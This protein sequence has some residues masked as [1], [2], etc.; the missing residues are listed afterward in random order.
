MLYISDMRQAQRPVLKHFMALRNE[1]VGNA[2]SQ[3]RRFIASDGPDEAAR[4]LCCA[5]LR[6]FGIDHPAGCVDITAELALQQRICQR[7]TMQRFHMNADYFAIPLTKCIFCGACEFLERLSPHRASSILK[8][9]D[10]I[11]P[12]F[13]SSSLV[14]GSERAAFALSLHPDRGLVFWACRRH[15]S[16]AHIRPHLVPPPRP[17]TIDQAENRVRVKLARS[18]FVGVELKQSSFRN[19]NWKMVRQEGAFT[20]FSTTNVTADVDVAHSFGADTLETVAELE[21][22]VVAT[23]S[24]VRRFAMN[25]SSVWKFWIEAK[26]NDFLKDHPIPDCCGFRAVPMESAFT[27]TEDTNFGE[28]LPDA[29]LV[30]YFRLNNGFGSPPPSA[31]FVFNEASG[32]ALH[33]FT[34]PLV[35]FPAELRKLYSANCGPDAGHERPVIFFHLAALMNNVKRRFAPQKAK[36]KDH[37][38]KQLLLRKLLTRDIRGPHEAD[39]H[40]L[41][42]PVPANDQERTRLILDTWKWLSRDVLHSRHISIRSTE[43]WKSV[44]SRSQKPAICLVRRPLSLADLLAAHNDVES[45]IFL[46]CVI[47]FDTS[48]QTRDLK[49]IREAFFMTQIWFRW[50]AVDY[51]WTYS[52]LNRKPRNNRGHP[53]IHPLPFKGNLG[54]VHVIVAF[55]ALNNARFRSRQNLALLRNVGGIFTNCP[56]HSGYRMIR[57]RSR[58]AKCDADGCDN[59]AT[60]KCSAPRD[61]NESFCNFKVCETCHL[62]LASEQANDEQEASTIAESN[63]VNS[64]SVVHQGHHVRGAI[65][66]NAFGKVLA[67]N[68]SLHSKAMDVVSSIF[69][70]ASGLSSTVYLEPLFFPQIFW[71]SDDSGAFTGISEYSNFLLIAAGALPLDLLADTSGTKIGVDSL[72]NH[73]WSRL[74][75]NYSVTATDEAYRGVCFDWIFN[76]HFKNRDSRFIFSRGAESIIDPLGDGL[77]DDFLKTS[78]FASAQ[79]RELPF[80][81]Y[82]SKRTVAELCA[83]ARQQ[84]LTHF[85]TLN[86]NQESFPGV[87]IWHR[88]LAE[89]GL[90]H[91]DYLVDLCRIWERSSRLFLEWIE[92]A[93]EVPLRGTIRNIWARYEFQTVEGHPPHLH[94]FF[95]V[96][97]CPEEYKSATTA[98]I[99]EL[100][101]ELRRLGCFTTEDMST[102][103]EWAGVV[104][105]H[106]CE[107]ARRRCYVGNEDGSKRCK[108]K[109]R[110]VLETHDYEIMVPPYSDEFLKLLE[111]LGLAK[112]NLTTGEY[113]L[114]ET[115]LDGKWDYPLD[116]DSSR[117]MSPFS[118]ILFLAVGGSHMNLQLTGGF[119]GVVAYATKYAAGE[120]ERALVTSRSS[121]V[122]REEAPHVL[123]EVGDIVNRKINHLEQDYRT[124]FRSRLISEP[125]LVW[126]LLGLPYVVSTF[127]MVHLDLRS[128]N[129]RPQKLRRDRGANKPDGGADELEAELVNI[130]DAVIPGHR[131]AFQCQLRRLADLICSG[132]ASDNVA[133]FDLRPP[134]LFRLFRNATEFH[135]HCI[136]DKRGVSKLTFKERALRELED[137]GFHCINGYNVVFR[138]EFLHNLQELD[139]WPQLSDEVQHIIRR[140]IVI[141][142]S[143]NRLNENDFYKKFVRRL[144]KGRRCTVIVH[145]SVNPIMQKSFLLQFLLRHGLYDSE[146]SLFYEGECGSLRA[147]FAKAGLLVDANPRLSLLRLL[148][149]YFSEVLTETCASFKELQKLLFAAQDAFESLF[150]E[151]AAPPSIPVLQ[152]EFEATI[153][154][155]FRNQQREAFVQLLRGISDE[156]PTFPGNRVLNDFELDF[157]S[158][159]KF[160]TEQERRAYSV[161]NGSGEWIPAGVDDTTSESVAE[162]IRARDRILQLILSRE[163][164]GQPFFIYIGGEP[165]TGKTYTMQ[166]IA[167]VLLTR[168][169]RNITLTTTA[170][171]RALEKGGL[172]IAELFGFQVYPSFDHENP[173]KVAYN[174]LRILQRHPNRLLRLCQLEVLLWEEVGLESNRKLQAIDAV[175]R[176]LRSCERPFGGVSIIASGHHMQLPSSA[177]G[178]QLLESPHFLYTFDIFLLK[179]MIRLRHPQHQQIVDELCRPVISADTARDLSRRIMETITNVQ[180]WDEVPLDAVIVFGIKEAVAAATLTTLQRREETGTQ[181]FRHESVD[182]KRLPHGFVITQDN[183]HRAALNKKLKEPQLLEVFVGCPVMMTRN[184]AIPGIYH[185][186]RGIIENIEQGEASITAVHVRWLRANADDLMTTLRPVYSCEVT[187]KPRLTLR[188]LQFPLRTVFAQTYHAVQGSQVPAIGTTITT[189]GRRRMWL[190]QQLIVLLSRPR[191]MR[192]I[193]NV[194]DGINSQQVELELCQL[195]QKRTQWLENV[196]HVLQERNCL[197][198]G[199]FRCQRVNQGH[200]A[201]VER[202]RVALPT[203]NTIGVYM[204][205]DNYD[206]VYIGY[207]TDIR[208]RIEMHNRERGAVFLKG[209]HNSRLVA[210]VTHLSVNEAKQ[211]EIWAQRRIGHR[212][213]SLRAAIDTLAEYAE[214]SFVNARVDHV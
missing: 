66:W 140:L 44:T 18:S 151:G 131:A 53:N 41:V 179:R 74:C 177:K 4:F 207:S 1:P 106:D 188:R 169:Y 92:K 181:V 35:S 68:T 2:V 34:V 109:P 117:K 155:E 72:T 135:T 113:D 28:K 78:G 145:K 96:D 173:A 147:L 184:H 118:P 76:I 197:R 87:R 60:F 95:S 125:E 46:S 114:V 130:Q 8:N 91:S 122:A 110:P 61:E 152:T 199:G 203:L 38:E 42:V 45:Y 101:E 55:A 156:I 129:E 209:R 73:V 200:H 115:L 187:P 137:V 119:R 57:T 84:T 75:S 9:R 19:T 70:R 120:E 23:R 43:D 111:E 138:E 134:E 201:Y 49:V 170:A 139:G 100:W 143:G 172:H 79:A 98:S 121:R 206:N 25:E 94:A 180:N 99:A 176:T 93:E 213:Q 10:L 124:H 90:P 62:T 196:D 102:F 22:F 97:G 108:V 212:P 185:G 14:Y 160:S 162:N 27:F 146:L 175:L 17:S 161:L 127:K 191:D 32:I 56:H 86:C 26:M 63:S 171:Q 24:D 164:S 67:R 54:Q 104:L 166:E 198:E 58:R 178:M 89:A 193:F 77:T 165:G 81:E 167:A 16:I 205:A 195:I 6:Q 30:P 211:L 194:L 59:A 103:C 107:K 183:A 40:A 5:L 48:T 153:L 83:A 148:R 52:N 3:N 88:T 33:T 202:P 123:H 116:G 186:A 142:V 112:L 126:F 47:G 85:F 20:G 15:G 158:R 80:S 65:F 133:L 71:H 82:D 64:A 210:M 11:V 136:V 192:Q 189:T 51:F 150:N 168:G 7:S 144:F 208:T 36:N 105:S 37:T 50:S 149:T 174:A 128:A 204:L 29:P 31:M 159:L 12:G 163:A 190:R 141:A 39:D 214:A 154:T 157:E 132:Y 69:A 21:Q 182:E 13:G